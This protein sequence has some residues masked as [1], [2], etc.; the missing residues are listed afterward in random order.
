MASATVR[1]DADTLTK[2]RALA[3][4]SGESMPIVLRRAIDA[5]ERAQFLEGLD[6]DFASLR[7]NPKAWSEEEIER[8]E[9]EATLAD[10]LENDPT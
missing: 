4:S 1:I 10:S 8:A 3:T 7:A 5:Y 2:L 6:R 9:W